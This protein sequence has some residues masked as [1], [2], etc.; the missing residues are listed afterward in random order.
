[1]PSPI[2]LPA[3]INL[4]DLLSL[5][6][7]ASP[8]YPLFERS[9]EVL[10]GKLEV[11]PAYPTRPSPRVGPKFLTI[12]MA[13]AND[14][15]GVYFTVQ[16][17]RMFHPEILDDIEILVIDN[18]SETSCSLAMQDLGNWVHGNFRY[19]PYR[20]HQSTAVSDL[21]FREAAGEF[22][23]AMD[24]HVLFEPGSLARL[25]RYWRENRESK[26]MVQGPMVSDTLARNEASSYFDPV[27]HM[28]F[29]GIPTYDER[30][31]TT[32][33][34]PFEIGMQT[35][36]CFGCRRA[37]WPGFNPRLS[38]YGGGEGYVQEKFRRAG[39][40]ALCLPFLRYLHRH[41]RPAG[42]HYPK[43]LA[44]RIRNYMIIGDELGIDQTPMIE[45]FR[46]CIGKEDTD[47]A[48]SVA[49]AEIEG[50]FHAFDGVYCVN[51]TEETDRWEAMRLRF[52]EMGIEAKVRRYATADTPLNRSIGQVLSHRRVIAEA[53]TQ[54]LESIVV[55]EDGNEFSSDAMAEMTATLGELAASS[56]Q[57]AFIDGPG[58]AYHCSIYD[59]ILKAIPDDAFCVARLVR[60]F[61]KGAKDAMRQVLGLFG[62][63]V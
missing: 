15:D 20:T 57:I 6:E 17:I 59:A 3:P 44:G 41:N 23:L 8:G 22:V 14:Y 58:I 62:V 63:H 48:V 25:I 34:P 31:I 13:T 51:R 52:V 16:A 30:V 46:E 33:E 4:G 56:W 7:Q 54:E 60:G 24:S 21:I 40:K 43:T 26:D 37:A 11:E 10:K 47:N 18:G 38:G 49:Q 2:P 12:G 32:E 29:Y 9:R 45:H 28:A 55:F 53:K 39:G 36:S 19:V 1:M 5:F 35:L 42:S 61:D 50:P 27:W